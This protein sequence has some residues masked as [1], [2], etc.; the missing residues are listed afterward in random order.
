MIVRSLLYGIVSSFVFRY[1][2]V[3]VLPIKIFSKCFLQLKYLKPIFDSVVRYWYV[4]LDEYVI[5]T[6][7]VVTAKKEARVNSKSL[8]SSLMIILAKFFVILINV[9]DKQ[10]N[11]MNAKFSFNSLSLQIHIDSLFRSIFD[12]F[13]EIITL[14]LYSAKLWCD[15]WP[16]NSS[17]I[18]N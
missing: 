10:Q 7:T 9:N 6:F 1:I 5:Q 12:L 18:C 2:R 17:I 14:T 13:I 11:N 16:Q 15:L 8:I 3:W 4:V